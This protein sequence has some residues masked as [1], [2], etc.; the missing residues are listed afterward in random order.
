[1]KNNNFWAFFCLVNTYAS[2]RTSERQGWDT[3][4]DVDA[5]AAA[6]DDVGHADEHS[7]NKG[8]AQNQQRRQKQ[9]QLRLQLQ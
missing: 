2:L 4:P 6:V 5:A 7:L 1:M 3:D 9:H 8:E